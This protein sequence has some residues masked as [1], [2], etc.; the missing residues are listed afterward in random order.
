MKLNLS[1]IIPDEI[2]F[3]DSDLTIHLE[4]NPWHCGCKLLFAKELL[5]QYSNFH[6]DFLCKSPPEIE[7]YPIK[8]SEFCPY[9]ITTAIPTET[10]ETYSNN[11]KEI[12]CFSPDGIAANHKVLI[13]SHI[14][15]MELTVRAGDALVTLENIDEDLALVWFGSDKLSSDS[16][17]YQQSAN[18]DCFSSF[19]K[20]IVIKNLDKA[21][22]YTFCLMSMV[23]TTV[24]PLDCMAYNHGEKATESDKIWLSEASK[25]MVISVI[26]AGLVSSIIVGMTTAAIFLKYIKYKNTES[27]GVNIFP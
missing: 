7:N 20:E 3:E 26:V 22:V 21:K 12:E 8:E 25:L 19:S 11:F 23:H 5:T 27:A 4:D 2:L 14:Q 15:L 17:K 24:S 16:S 18:I 6:G 9:P 10:T 1:P 13:Q